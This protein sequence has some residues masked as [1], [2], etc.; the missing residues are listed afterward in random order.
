MILAL[1]IVV[2]LALGAFLLWM[3]RLEKAIMSPQ[4]PTPQK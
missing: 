3:D 1:V 2:P 4:E